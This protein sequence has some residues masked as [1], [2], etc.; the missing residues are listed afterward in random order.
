MEREFTYIANDARC[1]SAIE[2][3]NAG[4]DILEW[5][6]KY[7]DLYINVT[8]GP[9]DHPRIAD[10]NYE[11]KYYEGIFEFVILYTRTHHQ[12]EDPFTDPKDY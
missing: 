10:C 4:M 3:L 2:D 12:H 7:L 5:L 8:Y 6:G 11:A 9:A 1:L